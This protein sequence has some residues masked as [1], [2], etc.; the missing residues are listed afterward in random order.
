MSIPVLMLLLAQGADP[1]LETKVDVRVKI[2]PIEEAVAALGK[3]AH[4][5]LG[6]APAIRDMKATI[7]V[8]KTPVRRVM[9]RLA[10]VMRLQWKKEATGYRLVNDPDAAAR[11][12]AYIKAE[13]A[14]RRAELEKRLRNMALA[15]RIPFLSLESETEA[16]RAAFAKLRSDDPNYQAAAERL[17]ALNN[18]QNLDTWS[19]GYLL[20]KLSNDGWNRL[21]NGEP[22][23]ASTSPTGRGIALPAATLNYPRYR[24]DQGQGMKRSRS[25]IFLRVDPE[26]WEL[27]TR[28]DDAGE[29]GDASSMSRSTDNGA[30]GGLTDELRDTPFAKELN[31]WTQDEFKDPAAQHKTNPKTPERPSEWWSDYYSNSDQL[32]WLHDATGLPIVAMASRT[33]N[34]RS[35]L[36]FDGTVADFVKGWRADG[37]FRME[38][39]FLMYRPAAFWY[40]RRTE[41]SEP[42]MRLLEAK[43]APTIDDYADFVMKVS[44]RQAATA[45]EPYSFLMRVSPYPLADGTTALRLWG[46]LSKPQHQI[47]RGGAPIPYAALS[48]PAR[49]AFERAVTDVFAG[50][51]H[52][53]PMASRFTGAGLTSFAGWGILAD[54]KDVK[55][56]GRSRPRPMDDSQGEYKMEPEVAGMALLLGKSKEDAVKYTLPLAGLPKKR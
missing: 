40:V 50:A 45:G 39:G 4:L 21:M 34:R 26:T 14:I 30:P 3:A 37:S 33:P 43:D 15:G 18:A 38:D 35:K 11:E 27:Q 29:N 2:V 49:Q 9:T 20:S 16:A 52:V 13:A 41:I 10:D 31:A 46:S 5:N 42:V 28:G 56:T 55:A 23:S 36:A 48:G 1:Q 53:G 51:W 22:M 7:L 25:D 47:L 24:G 8:D 17:G 44:D 6:I 54:T 32:E 12:A 19:Q